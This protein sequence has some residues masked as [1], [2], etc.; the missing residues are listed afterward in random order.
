HVSGASYGLQAL[1]GRSATM[2]FGEQPAPSADVTLAWSPQAYQFQLLASTALS[3]DAVCAREPVLCSPF[4]GM[5]V[6]SDGTLSGSTES[7][8]AQRYTLKRGETL[9][10]LGSVTPGAPTDGTLIALG[11]RTNGY[12][13]FLYSDGTNGRLMLTGMKFVNGLRSNIGGYRDVGAA[14]TSQR[15]FSLSVTPG[16]RSNTI[17]ISAGDADIAPFT[18]DS[19]RLIGRP[20]KVL[21]SPGDPQT[22]FRLTIRTRQTTRGSD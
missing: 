2:T 7:T 17:A 22:R 19:L 14:D 11:D 13:L 12:G 16:E 8:S 18:D 20:V 3:R 5:N 21:L 6:A 9:A 10:V 15:A 4:A 1:A